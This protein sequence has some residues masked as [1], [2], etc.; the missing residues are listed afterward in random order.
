M[1][2]VVVSV[3]LIIVGSLYTIAGIAIGKKFYDNVRKE[4]HQERGK[5]IQKI[6]K[7]YALVQCIGWPIVMILAWLLYINKFVLTILQHD[8]T[9]QA[10]ISLRFGYTMF[11]VYVGF[12]SLI[13]AICR[14]SFIIHEDQVFKFGVN[15]IRSILQ[16]CSVVIPIVLA[17]SIFMERLLI[18]SSEIL[19]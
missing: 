12:N 4:E 3:V 11:R 18:A 8:I 5:V 19:G 9:R 16:I 15:R 6:M 1:Q 17:L 14:Y 10:M 2:F 13:I 7:T